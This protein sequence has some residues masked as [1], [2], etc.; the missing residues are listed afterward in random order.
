MELVK[1]AIQMRPTISVVLPVY[2]HRN[3]VIEAI[4]SVFEQTIVPDELIIIDDGS[5]DGSAKKIRE[6][7]DVHSAPKGLSVSF[8]ARENRGAHVTINEGIRRAKSDY[9]AILN[10]DDLYMLN[11]LE[12]CLHTAL[13]QKSRLV[14]TYVDAIDGSGSPL[15]AGEMWRIWYNHATL[16]NIQ[17]HDCISQTLLYANIA[18]STGNFF[19]HRTLFD[20]VGYF[21]NLR[22]CHDWDFLLRASLVEEPVVLREKLYKYRIHGGN[23]A[24]EPDNYAIDETE[25][26]IRDHLRAVFSTTPKNKW[27]DILSEHGF[28]FG[29]TGWLGLVAPAFNMLLEKPREAKNNVFV[30]RR[31]RPRVRGNGKKVTILSHEMTYT[32][33]PTIVLELTNALIDKGV[34]VEVLTQVDGPLRQEFENMDVPVRVVRPITQLQNLYDGL[35][36][37][38]E[39]RRGNWRVAKVFREVVR[40]L[41]RM[42]QAIRLAKATR[43]TRGVLLINSF[44]SWPVGLKLLDRW[45]GP[46]FWYVHETYD[47]QFMM[48]QARENELLKSL[49]DSGRV[50]MLYGSD[51]T[52]SLWASCGYNGVVRYWSGISNPGSAGAKYPIKSLEPRSRRVILSV[53]TAGGRKGTRHLVEAFAI[54]RKQGII[55]DDVEL[56]IV[57]CRAPSHHPQTRDLVRRV[58]RPDLFGFVRLVPIV[59]PAVLETYFD[60][61][62]IYVQSSLME[63]VPIALLEAMSRG[64]PIITTD[65]DG[66]KEAVVDG[67]SGILV[68]PRQEGAMA[69][70]MAKLL[71]DEA[72]ALRLG[73]AAKKRF[74]EHF[75]LEATVEPIYKMLVQ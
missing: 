75:A 20:D 52:R 21:S 19:I 23:T 40:V 47:P 26:V 42:T 64:L 66:C 14:F 53:G 41:L 43:N 8:E 57:G 15:P 44:A 58:H 34:D 16:L 55:P 37:H 10:S 46:A 56:C 6:F 63:G 62:D 28:F 67:V 36:R 9:I 49:F 48:V 12:R 51:A 33:A 7:L 71:K 70:A 27:S 45:R 54:G 25:I 3:Y 74:A 38:V 31:S 32:G 4:R 72:T 2:N 39:R 11:R 35:Q 50:K 18:V 13:A 30:P 24:M 17:E 65:V 1:E 60:E 68:P 73:N 5:T 59:E 61:A 69:E 22:Y 29:G